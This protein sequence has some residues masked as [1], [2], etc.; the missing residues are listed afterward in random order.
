MKTVI[1]I[2][3]P[4]Y[5]SDCRTITVKNQKV[6]A[7]TLLCF[8]VLNVALGMLSKPIENWIHSGLAMFG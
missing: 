5:R 8:M 3:V 1:R 6:Y 2:Y 7:L 4:D